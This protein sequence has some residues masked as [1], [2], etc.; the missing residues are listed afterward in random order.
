MLRDAA[1]ARLLSMRVM[2]W[3][4]AFLRHLRGARDK[5][6]E[7]FCAE[8]TKQSRLSPRMHSGLLRCARNDGVKAHTEFSNARFKLQT[9]FLVL[10][11]HCARA[12]LVVSPSSQEEGAGKTGCR[13]APVVR[14]AQNAQRQLHSGRHRWAGNARP[15][16]R[17][18]LTA[19]GELSPETNS[20]LPPSPRGLAIHQSRSGRCISAKA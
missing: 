15:S 2:D 11:A 4:A 8:A 9:Q 6:A 19:Y 17:S 10:A 16:L 7:Q 1:P 13:L 5:I 18:G 14:C 3:S 20:L 12:M